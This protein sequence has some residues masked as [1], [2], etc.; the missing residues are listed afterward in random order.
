MEKRYL[1]QQIKKDLK[2]K[3]VFLA[4]PRQIGKTTLAL[5]LLKKKAGYLSWDIP[6][7]REKILKRQYPAAPLIAFDEIHKYRLW[8]NYVKGLYDTYKE[9]FKIL[10]NF[11]PTIE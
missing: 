1:T 2:S 5:S 4:G 7:Q 3:M 6:E 10:V 9:Q 11:V 8:K